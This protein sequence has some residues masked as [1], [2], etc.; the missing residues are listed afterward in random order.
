[1]TN[2]EKKKLRLFE[3]KV[4]QLINSC[5]SLRQD[6]NSLREVIK[7]KDDD[8]RDLNTQL[9]ASRKDYDNLKTAKMMEISD[10]DLQAARQRI[11]RLVREV[12]KCIALLKQEGVSIDTDDDTTPPYGQTDNT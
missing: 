12:N 7:Q 3:A 1:M 9:E 5:Q 10:G 8:I 2:E 6:N 11:T 4:Q